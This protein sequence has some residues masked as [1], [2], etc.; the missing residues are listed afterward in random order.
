VAF[1]RVAAGILACGPG[2]P[3]SGAAVPCR[4]QL[5]L[6]PKSGSRSKMTLTGGSWLLAKEEGGERATGMG[7][8]SWRTRAVRPRRG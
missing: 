2:V 1:Y 8:S 5:G 6:E 3:R 7:E 4:G